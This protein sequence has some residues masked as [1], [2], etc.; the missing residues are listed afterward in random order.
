MT[1]TSQE[2]YRSERTPQSLIQEYIDASTGIFERTFHQGIP[3]AIEFDG[4]LNALV[5]IQFPGVTERFVDVPFS[6]VR[7][8]IND[9]VIVRPDLPAELGIHYVVDDVYSEAIWN[10]LCDRK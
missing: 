4:S 9:E 5:C 1:M 7:E 3:A 2:A 6:K 10:V 8:F